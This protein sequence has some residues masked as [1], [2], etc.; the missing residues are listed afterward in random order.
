MQEF[1]HSCNLCLFKTNTKW[2]LVRHWKYHTTN[3]KISI[4]TNININ[5]QWN[6]SIWISDHTFVLSLREMKVN[7]ITGENF[8]FEGIR[9]LEDGVKFIYKDKEKQ[10]IGYPTVNCSH[11]YDIP[12]KNIIATVFVL[13][14]IIGHKNVSWKEINKVRN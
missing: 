3:E 10:R 1:D 6:G 13:H 11:R 4:S 9:L 2:E 8:L 7:K 5:L 14:E 12:I